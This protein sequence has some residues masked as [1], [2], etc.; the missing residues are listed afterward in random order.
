MRIVYS[1]P[2]PERRG[3]KRLNADR[4]MTATERSSKRYGNKKAR[5]QKNIAILDFETDPFDNQT[6]ARIFPFLA[7]LYSDNFPPVIIWD[8]QF[9]AFVKRIVAAI[10]ALPEPYTIYAHN[11]GRFDFMF[12]I[13]ELRGEV[14]FK[15]RGIMSA[16]LGDHTLRD[17]FHILPDKL[18]NLHKEKFAYE[19]MA[20]QRRGDYR[21]EIID[22][23]ISDCRYLLDHVKAFIKSFGIKMSIGQAAMAELSQHYKVKKLSPGWDEY[24]RT[25][26]FG[27]RV[28]CLKGAGYWHGDFKLYDVNSM[29]PFVMAHRKHP[30]GDIWDY[31]LRVGEPDKNTV[32]VDL[33]CDNNNALIARTDE[34]ETTARIKNG[35]FLTTIHEYKTAKKYSLIKNISINFCVDCKLQSNFSKFVL[36]IYAQRQANKHTLSLLKAAGKEGTPEFFEQKK[37]DTLLKFLLNNAYGKFAQNPRRFKRYFI[38]DPDELPPDQWF[39]GL[40]DLPATERDGYMLPEFESEH[41]WIWCKPDPGFR[42]NNVGT[43]ASITGAA[44][45]ML[46]EALQHAKGAIYCDT[47]SI[48]CRELSGV[49]ID[50]EEL[51]AWDLED[52]FSKVIID[53]KKLYSCWFKK[54]RFDADG[55]ISEY[56]IRSKGTSGL[57][58][59]DMV[60][61]LSGAQ[62]PVTNKAPTLTR[63]GEQTYITR[64]IRA[65]VQ[66]LGDLRNDKFI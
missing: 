1:D 27:G 31:D 10:L 55:Q 51:G 2:P 48:I 20:R 54:P 18:A 11:G 22:Y 49:Q 25:F 19:N 64:N 9:P 32:F 59:A 44:R 60:A 28:E 12:L 29:Y 7:V 23:C 62:I 39:K 41:Y 53:G 21:Q 47:D 66:T 50:K 8:E 58:W 63:Y 57:T 56:K 6:K 17:S 15:G 13:S 30:I 38:T 46:L 4:V 24:L 35:R 65:T 45:A 5:R 34:G 52:E 61:L 16:R 36:P 26:F 3:R 33:D 43:A 40:E 42:F 14:S 37:E